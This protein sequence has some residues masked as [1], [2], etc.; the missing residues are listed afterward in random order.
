MNRGCEAL[1]FVSAQ[2]AS[3]RNSANH[4]RFNTV[5]TWDQDIAKEAYNTVVE[6]SSYKLALGHADHDGLPLIYP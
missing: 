2:C 1:K 6:V 5:P 4:T 3:A